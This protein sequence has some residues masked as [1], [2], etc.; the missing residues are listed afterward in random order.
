M[1]DGP[2]WNHELSGAAYTVYSS[3]TMKAVVG[4][5]NGSSRLCLSCHDGTVAIGDLHSSGTPVTMVNGVTT[6][7][8][9]PA[10]MG[11][12][13]SGHH[14]VSF[15][16]DAA[17]AAADGNLKQPSTILPPVRLDAQQRV[18]C[19]SCHDPHDNTFGSFLV[20]DNTGSTL[21][22]SCHLMNRWT[23]AASHR[24]STKNVP[25]VLSAPAA[26]SP[27]GPGTKLAN[28]K[29][30]VAS[31]GC[32]SC[33]ATHR[34]GSRQS[35]LRD[36]IPDQTCF[37][38]HDG[39]FGK[40]VLADYNKI[41]GHNI[42]PIKHGGH[43]PTE[44]L[45]NAPRHVV[46]QDCHDPHGSTSTPAVAPNAAGAISGV[47]GVNA[48]GAAMNAISKEFELCFRCHGDS[49]N[50]GPARI[51]RAQ[52]QTNTRIEFMP[53]NRSFHPIEAPGRNPSVPSL[54][55]P[56]SIASV[57][58]CTDCHNSD[59]AASNGGNGAR[60]PHGSQFIPLLERSLEL[61]D[62][63]L[64]SPVTY[65]LCYKCHSRTSLL[66]DDLHRRHLVDARAAC[67]TCHDSHASV[68]K[69]HLINF[70][71]DYV[72][73]NA[74]GRLDYVGGNCF[75]SC[76]GKSHGDPAI[77]QR[78][79]GIRSPSPVQQLAPAP[80]RSLPGPTPAGR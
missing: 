45:V 66:A 46:C 80:S 13:L 37:T 60:G 16:Y 31:L 1:T 6:M 15:L 19:I 17:L 51:N 49:V 18:Q 41:S 32:D 20:L 58:Y 4:Q 67:T 70:N 62:Y 74:A 47:R 10:N 3:P 21:C 73:P 30:T 35:L 63:Q 12:D 26:A 5:P 52:V 78:P 9:G 64:E 54:I 59:Q 28:R 34:S 33:H 55:A 48:S 11:T 24:S 69:P 29:S 8:A 23:Q 50:R 65:A 68:D 71:I 44:D 56:L 25:T 39:Q 77:T 2:L 53:S 38:C 72:S 27:T 57:I 43:S 7:P 79:V 40:N 61:K 14:P 36:D 22:L 42:L 76:H 75:L